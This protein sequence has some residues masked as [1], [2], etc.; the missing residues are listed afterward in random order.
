MS[1]I[2]RRWTFGLVFFIIFAAL[3][4]LAA[5]EEATRIIRFVP[6]TSV[7]GDRSGS[8][9]TGSIAVSRPDAWRCMI[10]NGIFDPCFSS[11]GE[12]FVVCNPNPSKGEPGFRLNLTEPLPKQDMPAPFSDVETG[13]G[14]LVELADGTMCS[15]VTGA[16]GLIG[17]KVVRYY[18]EN[19]KKGE[20]I[21]LLGDLNSSNPLWTAEKA[22]TVQG[23][24]GP[25]LIKSERI[26]VRT[27]W[28]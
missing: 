16:S 28:Q 11:P 18:C 23:R 17:G 21:S 12:K 19:R 13:S 20:D 6:D 14:W 9:W 26:A 4:A 3:T 1:R 27:V 15:P 24:G 22:T 7:R 2:K 5:Q 25:K 8:C 10:G